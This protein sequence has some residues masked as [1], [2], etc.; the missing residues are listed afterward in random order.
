M[1]N[2]NITQIFMNNLNNDDKWNQWF[3]GL[4]DGDGCFYIAKKV[5]RNS[6]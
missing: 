1:I 3:A 4:T 2:L 5:N 6:V